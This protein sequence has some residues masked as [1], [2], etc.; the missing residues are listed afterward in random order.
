MDGIFVHGK[1]KKEHDHALI[2]F[3]NRIKTYGIHKIQTELRSFLGA[4]NFYN[5][6]I[7][8]VNKLREPFDE[9]LHKDTRWILL[10]IVLPCILL[11]LNKSSSSINTTILS[12]PISKY[13]TYLAT[14]A[15]FSFG[16][17]INIVD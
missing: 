6:F 8:R 2:N 1:N 16:S 11:S 7:L 4:I 17:I 3:V 15:R 12:R 9:L 14:R 10:H 5:K 13:T